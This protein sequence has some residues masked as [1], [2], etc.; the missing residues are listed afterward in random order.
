MCQCEFGKQS[1][2][3][4]VVFGGSVQRVGGA[5]GSPASRGVAALSTAYRKPFD[6]LTE[7]LSLSSC[8][9][10]DVVTRTLDRVIQGFREALEAAKPRFPVDCCRRT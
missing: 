9:A 7:G 6:L 1:G 5:R 2:K 8:G 10:D 3:G 4:K